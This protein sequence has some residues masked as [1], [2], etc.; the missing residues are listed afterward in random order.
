[1]I[2]SMRETEGTVRLEDEVSPCVAEG[3]KSVLVLNLRA[4][5]G[6]LSLAET[7]RRTQLD[8]DE[9]RRIERGETRGMNFATMMKITE[10][11]GCSLTDLLEIAPRP[12]GDAP[13]RY[14]NIL[15]AHARGELA[16]APARHTRRSGEADEMDLAEAGEFQFDAP[17]RRRSRGLPTLNS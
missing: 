13:P 16:P 3:V 11:L 2:G 5:R 4:L 6:D 9:L 15:A 1:M 7:A 14:A 17:P 10:G 8:R 12:G